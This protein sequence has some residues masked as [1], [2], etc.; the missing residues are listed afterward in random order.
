MQHVSKE[1]GRT[2]LFVS[3]AIS[4]VKKLCNH[5]ILLQSGKMIQSG[6]ISTIINKYEELQ[7]I[8][9]TSGNFILAGYKYYLENILDI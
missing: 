3:H 4:T 5:G 2:V 7:D 6:E 8:N 9:L 1:E